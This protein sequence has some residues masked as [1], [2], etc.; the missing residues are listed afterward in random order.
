MNLILS[1]YYQKQNSYIIYIVFIDFDY[2]EEFTRF[3]P[4]TQH[5]RAGRQRKRAVCGFGMPLFVMP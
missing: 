4:S 1:A 5:R 2:I 3:S